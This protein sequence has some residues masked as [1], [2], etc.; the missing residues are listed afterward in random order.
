MRYFNATKDY[1]MPIIVDE[2]NIV[3]DNSDDERKITIECVRFHT[4][5]TYL[6]NRNDTLVVK[7]K[8]SQTKITNDWFTCKID[9]LVCN[10]TT[11]ADIVPIRTMS[12]MLEPMI[13]S[14][15]YDYDGETERF[16]IPLLSPIYSNDNIKC[17]ISNKLSNKNV[18]TINSTKGT[19]EVTRKV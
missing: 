11:F 5:G 1:D 3:D 17:S 6:K 19:I 9:E 4:F 7:H 13:I 15:S 10:Y 12:M 16:E 18:L 14:G 8:D 2:P